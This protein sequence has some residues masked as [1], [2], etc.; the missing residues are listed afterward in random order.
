MMSRRGGSLKQQALSSEFQLFRSQ[1][2]FFLSN[3]AKITKDYFNLLRVPHYIKNLFVFMPGFFAEKM[4]D[5]ES[6]TRL[7]L[8]FVAFSLLASSVYI[9]NDL[10]DRERDA[11]HPEKKN[12]P[13]A[14]GRFSTNHASLV[15]GMCLG[16]AFCIG[17][18][19]IP[20]AFPVFIAYFLMNLG[21]SFYL[22]QLAIVDVVTIALGFDLRLFAGGYLIDVELSVW[23]VL[24]TFLLALFLA[25]GKRR[26]DYFLYTQGE[27]KARKSLDGYNLAFL[28]QAMGVCAAVTIVSYIMY[29][30]T[31]EVM[32][33]LNSRWVYVSAVFVIVAIFR[34]FQL[35]VV[36]HKSGS[37][38]MIC[39]KDRQIQITLL[40]WLSFFSYLI[41]G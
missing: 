38:T 16:T 28:D 12:R 41:Y 13:I 26:D 21:Y 9:L 17:L 34:Y 30:V 24:M 1:L 6:L 7:I 4:T 32:L 37:P 29:C 33:R 36:E 14:A 8:L 10:V 31:D 35:T 22:K 25:L 2:G 3:T 11:H 39:L 19:F 23:I 20:K 18:I 27:E 40:F 15:L 5:P